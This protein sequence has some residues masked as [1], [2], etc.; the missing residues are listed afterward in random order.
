MTTDGN[1]QWKSSTQLKF[2][3]KYTS[4][5]TDRSYQNA[6]EKEGKPFFL[7]V[8]V[9]NK[10]TCIGTIH[11]E[12]YMK[13]FWWKCFLHICML[14][15][16]NHI[17]DH[18]FELISRSLRV[19]RVKSWGWTETCLFSCGCNLQRFLF[20]LLCNAF[21]SGVFFSCFML[22]LVAIHHVW[23]SVVKQ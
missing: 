20:V 9:R 13:V 22:A 7:E 5:K 23:W 8:L 14:T 4:N 15:C 16:V 21:M 11:S 12:I 3:E 17:V 6:V 1:L 10:N 19:F 18:G 2:Q